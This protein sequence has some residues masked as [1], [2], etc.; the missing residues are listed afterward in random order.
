[1]FQHCNRS[2]LK[3]FPPQFSF[4]SQ[5]HFGPTNAH[6]HKSYIT[7]QKIVIKNINKYLHFKVHDLKEPCSPGRGLLLFSFTPRN[8]TGDMSRENC[9]TVPVTL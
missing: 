4:H 3:K 7:C 9:Q 6:K 2:Y 1:M 8:E 5:T